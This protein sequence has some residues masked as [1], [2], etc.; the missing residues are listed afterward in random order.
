[1]NVKYRFL[2]HLIFLLWKVVE[3]LRCDATRWEQFFRICRLAVLDSF[4][5][6][7]GNEYR[8]LDQKYEKQIFWDLYYEDFKF[9]KELWLKKMQI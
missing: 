4:N 8:I 6:S 7:Y 5:M 2:I 1:M 3:Y 9:W